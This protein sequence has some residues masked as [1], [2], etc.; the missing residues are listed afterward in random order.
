M[1][2]QCTMY[3]LHCVVHDPVTLSVLLWTVICLTVSLNLLPQYSTQP[4]ST[5]FTL[6][7]APKKTLPF[8]HSFASSHIKGHCLIWQLQVATYHI[9][10]AHSANC[11]NVQW[12]AAT[13]RGNWQPSDT[14]GALCL[15]VYLI[16]NAA[17]NLGYYMMYFYMAVTTSG[18]WNHVHTMTYANYRGIW[19]AYTVLM[20]KPHEGLLWRVRKRSQA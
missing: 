5:D 11:P 7:P 15:P 8:P 18:E 19:N 20:G 6:E 10:I 13:G 1:P 3:E 17:R 14:T 4:H 9:N 12:S 16:M 2:T